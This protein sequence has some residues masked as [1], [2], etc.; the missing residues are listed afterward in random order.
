MLFMLMLCLIVSCVTY[1]A[2][3]FVCGHA[4]QDLTQGQLRK[5]C[6]VGSRYVKRD[7]IPY[8]SL[9]PDASEDEFLNKYAVLKYDDR[10]KVTMFNV[11]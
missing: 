2:V 3:H 1:S 4:C 8:R 5:L 9:Y 7:K 10:D 11:A 6:V